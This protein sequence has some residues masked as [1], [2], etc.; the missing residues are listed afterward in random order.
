MSADPD[1]KN[2][3]RDKSNFSEPTKDRLLPHN[4]EA[5]IGVLA[6][7]L[8]DANCI[9]DCWEQLPHGAEE[10]YDHRHKELF[11]CFTE[12]HDR[13]E[14]I[15]V[16]TVQAVLKTRNLLD[17][18]GGIQF[19]ASLPDKVPSA[20]NLAY[21]TAI[22]HEKF[23]MRRLIQTC[24]EVVGRVY[25]HQGEL[26]PLLDQ[27]ERDLLKIC[28][29]NGHLPKII[30]ARMLT[31][32]PPSTPPMLI[33]NVCHEATKMVLG[34]GSKTCK[35]WV[36]LYIALCVAGGYKCFDFD[37]R[38]SPVL[39]VNCEIPEAFY[40][41]RIAR[42][43]KQMDI[44]TPELLD[45]WN[46]RGHNAP[47]DQI[48]PHIEQKITHR[49]YKL[50]IL[51]PIY[52]LYGNLDENK[53]SDITRLMN[54]IEAMIH[55][56]GA[57]VAFAAHFSKGN[58][59]SKEVM[60]RISGSGVFG[61]DPDTILTMTALEN[62][63]TFTLEGT[64]RNLPA[65]QP[66]GLEWRYPLMVRDDSIDTSRLKKAGGRGKAYD[67]AKVVG[68][69]QDKP[70]TTTQWHK[71]SSSELG[72]SKSAFFRC[73]DDVRRQSLAT[74]SKIDSKWSAPTDAPVQEEFA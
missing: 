52:K 15:D 18:I 59:S 34:G 47:F 3:R 6:C 1:L 16:I 63:N 31:D 33:N 19:L 62:P 66:I 32:Q 45:V 8:L 36:L 30:S 27:V 69:L 70:L 24:T 56:T 60:D 49:K 50:V 23:Q 29:G 39:V 25:D 55:R 71:L 26:H 9:H 46:L 11:D 57:A 54:A 5:E 20:A 48:L 14:P 7:I 43:C 64:L 10:F 28:H 53:A 12:L 74:Q 4:P 35:T 13:R 72:M 37:T 51:D 38:K 61:R 67:I 41:N 42:V 58:Q 22:V 44:E 21:Y 40:R 65:F 2:S 17:N 73:L 68:L